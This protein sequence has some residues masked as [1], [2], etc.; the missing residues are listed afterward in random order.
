MLKVLEVN[1]NLQGKTLAQEN[2]QRKR[3]LQQAIHNLAGRAAQNRG[4]E[5]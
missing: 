1:H 2:V 5:T 4:F 3:K